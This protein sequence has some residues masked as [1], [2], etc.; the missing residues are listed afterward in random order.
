MARHA[1]VKTPSKAVPRESAAT[2]VAPVPRVAPATRDTPVNRAPAA[3]VPAPR[4][5]AAPPAPKE[6]APRPPAVAAAPAAPAV[7]KEASEVEQHGRFKVCAETHGIRLHRIHVLSATKLGSFQ[8]TLVFDC[9]CG[10]RW[11]LR[12]M[13]GDVVSVDTGILEELRR[14]REGQA[15]APPGY[16]G[17]PPGLAAPAGD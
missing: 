4:G 13:Q 1:P 12:V 8:S 14:G 17:A 3:R 16:P 7:L 6:A 5:A 9:V 11:L 2:R 15:T 10:Q